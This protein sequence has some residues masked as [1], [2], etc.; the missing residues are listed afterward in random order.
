M[1]RESSLC[2]LGKNMKKRYFIVRPI[3]EGDNLWKVC[4]TTSKKSFLDVYQMDEYKEVKD[5]DNETDPVKYARS[6]GCKRAYII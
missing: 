3:W 4:S 1:F 5:F 2:A 6:K